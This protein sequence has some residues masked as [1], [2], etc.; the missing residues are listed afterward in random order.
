MHKNLT[1]IMR[2]YQKLKKKK[3]KG[4]EEKKQ[5]KKNRRKNLV[6]S[7]SFLII[8]IKLNHAVY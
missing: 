6:I 2:N 7:K 3:D 5:E 1:A 4:N 8:F